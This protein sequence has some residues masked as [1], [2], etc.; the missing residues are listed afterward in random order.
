M[1][2][3]APT[4]ESS[5]DDE[6]P[7]IFAELNITPFTDVILVLLIIVMVSASAMVEQAKQ[8][9]VDV[10]LPR[11]GTGAAQP[12][13]EK[14]MVIAV[15]K[16]GRTSIDGE[17]VGESE[18]ESILRERYAKSPDTFIVLD[19]DGELAHRVVV[20]HLDVARRIGFSNVGIGVTENGQ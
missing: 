15:L 14:I 16:D 20:R 4:P 11:A 6:S 2:V 19:A 5:S 10:Q 18:L 1:A 9:Y 7:P 12:A 17:V 8:G 13:P 3:Q